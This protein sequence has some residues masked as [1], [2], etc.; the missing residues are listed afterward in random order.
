MIS[1]KPAAR[2]CGKF[3][4]FPENSPENI[5]HQKLIRTTGRNP[6]RFPRFVNMKLSQI[7][8]VIFSN[9]SKKNEDSGN[10][11]VS[12]GVYFVYKIGHYSVAISPS[13][14]YICMRFNLICLFT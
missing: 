2:K 5:R 6:I 8:R 13:I 7:L 4:H 9:E 1:T 3:P 11:V 10:I 14:V 12:N